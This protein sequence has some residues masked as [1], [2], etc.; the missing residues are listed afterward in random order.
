M[1]GQNKRNKYK[2]SIISKVKYNVPIK[3]GSYI[4]YLYITFLNPLL[5]LTY[6]L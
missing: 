3:I 4:F 2:A 6:T 5:L 1:R